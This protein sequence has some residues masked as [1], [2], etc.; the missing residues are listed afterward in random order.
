MCTKY[1]GSSNTVREKV[2]RHHTG[3]KKE[4]CH[5]YVIRQKKLAKESLQ[6]TL[7]SKNFKYGKVERKSII[8]QIM[9]IYYILQKCTQI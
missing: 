4:N 1:T 7:R 6:K 5:Q 2:F 9:D 8:L 3:A